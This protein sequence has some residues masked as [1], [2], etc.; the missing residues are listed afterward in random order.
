MIREMQLWQ[1]YKQTTLISF[2]LCKECKN[3]LF[4]DKE[5]VTLGHNDRVNLRFSL[6][7]LCRKGNIELKKLVNAYWP[8]RP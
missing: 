7:A 2:I 3:T 1:L 6:C 4:F 5:K 8:Y